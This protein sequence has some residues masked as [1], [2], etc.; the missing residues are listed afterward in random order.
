MSKS[1]KQIVD[2]AI[3]NNAVMMFSKTYCPFCD[4]AK[5]ALRAAGVEDYE[6]MEMENR[7]DCSEMQDYLKKLTGA[8]SVPRVF[9]H[10]KCIGG[11]SE[12]KA[13]QKSGKLIKMIRKQ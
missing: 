4:M 8:R 7:S 5:D 11:G 12:A 6:L 2:D 3:A 13:L 10:G 1:V 9:I